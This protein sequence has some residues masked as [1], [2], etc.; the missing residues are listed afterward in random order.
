MHVAFYDSITLSTT[1]ES[2]CSVQDNEADR[3]QL[4]GNAM[5]YPNIDEKTFINI[6]H[7]DLAIQ[8]NRKV[9]G[10]TGVHFPRTGRSRVQEPKSL[11]SRLHQLLLRS[12]FAIR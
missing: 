2:R 5:W 6:Y 7:Q 10:K 3:N 9:R 8:F 4:K 11:K 1:A 12:T